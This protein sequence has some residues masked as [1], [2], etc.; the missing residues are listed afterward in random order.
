[1]TRMAGHKIS[2]DGNTIVCTA[3]EDAWC[4]SRPECD[5]EWWDKD[6]CEEHAG[7]HPLTTGHDCWAIEWINAPRD[8][9]LW[10]CAD[11]WAATS[12]L[13]IIPGRAVVLTGHGDNGFTW[14][15]TNPSKES[16]S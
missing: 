2:D 3:T 4:R 14:T 15:Y 8:T 10:E 11:D 16:L 13:P 7:E 12:D 9:E 5:T 6:G 1:M